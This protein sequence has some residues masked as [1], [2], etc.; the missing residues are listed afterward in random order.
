VGLA[1]AVDPEGVS[2][3][4]AVTP[5]SLKALVAFFKALKPAVPA[6]AR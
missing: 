2:L 1:L 5:E 3:A 6:E 4:G